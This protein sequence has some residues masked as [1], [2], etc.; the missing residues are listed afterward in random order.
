MMKHTF[1]KKALLLGVA[2]LAINMPIAAMELPGNISQQISAEQNKY[3]DMP[4][5]GLEK[6]LKTKMGTLNGYWKRMMHCIT[7]DKATGEI[8]GERC[9]AGQITL[10]IVTLIG[11]M[12]IVRLIA[13]RTAAGA[14]TETERRIGGAIQR[15]A[16]SAR[17]YAGQQAETLRSRAGAVRTYAEQQAGALKR[18][19]TAR[20][21]R[22]VPSMP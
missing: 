18:G 9:T 10:V 7:G 3:K 20:A 21:A 12:A 6:E 16:T 4:Q 14:W 8:S 2:A 13:T 19:A 5:E 22:Y 1:A 17:T 15:G 11:I